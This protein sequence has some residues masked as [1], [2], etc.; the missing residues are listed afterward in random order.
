MIETRQ[1]DY[2]VIFG[3]FASSFLSNRRILPRKHSEIYSYLEKLSEKFTGR[4]RQFYTM[5][6]KIHQT[7]YY[8]ETLTAG[9]LQ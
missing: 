8:Y 5:S 2:L 3:T 4:E 6:S 7:L 9:T 1:A